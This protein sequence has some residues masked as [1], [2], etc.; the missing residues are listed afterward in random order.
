MMTGKPDEVLLTAVLDPNQ[1]VEAR[2]VGYN[3]TTRNGRELTGIISAETST[4]ITLRTQGGAEET[5]LRSDI[6]DMRSSGL[7]LMPEGLEQT[8][9]PADFADLFAFLRSK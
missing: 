6:T 1:A 4:S 7:S 5:L 9:K 2:Y 8:L 3:V